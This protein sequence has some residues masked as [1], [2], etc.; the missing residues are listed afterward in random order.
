MIQLEGTNIFIG[1]RADSRLR[2]D[3]AWAVVN[4]AKTVHC[5][6]MGWGN[7]TPRDHP[8]Y[9][10]YENEQ[11]L[12]FNWVDGNAFL[13]K[14]SGP[15]AFTRALDFIEEWSKTKNVLINCD[16]GQSRSP[17]V[18]LLYLAKRLHVIPDG[19]F[20]EARAAFERLYPGYAPSG[21][22]DFVA[23]NWDEIH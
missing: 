7:V 6:I 16:Q 8:N 2:T 15:A 14:M 10:S 21:I 5:E 9:L 12:S 18:A 20:A 1:N 19:S 4:T 23:T 13:Y 22:A 17:T 11:L 3:P